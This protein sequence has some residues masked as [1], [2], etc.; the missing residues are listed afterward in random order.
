MEDEWNKKFN[1]GMYY[2]YCI[3]EPK[4]FIKQIVHIKIVYIINIHKYIKARVYS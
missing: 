2:V 1:H 3:L 4:V